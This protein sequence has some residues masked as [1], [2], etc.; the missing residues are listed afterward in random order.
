MLAGCLSRYGD[1]VPSASLSGGGVPG[2]GE[3]GKEAQRKEEG[4]CL[5]LHPLLCY[6]L[7]F[8]DLNI[9]PCLLTPTAQ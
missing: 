2:L 9:L 5:F 1:V 6:F 3:P 4:V 8:A 7:G